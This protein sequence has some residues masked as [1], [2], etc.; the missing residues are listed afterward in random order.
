MKVFQSQHNYATP[1][2]RKEFSHRMLSILIA[3]F[4]VTTLFAV[5]LI[6]PEV[7]CAQAAGGDMP[8]ISGLCK[9]SKLLTGPI[10]G[11]IAI[12]ILAVMGLAYAA[13]EEKSVMGRGG[14]IIIGLS[15]TFFAASLV[16]YFMGAAV[17]GFLCR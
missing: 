17:S 3:G 8:W 7:A 15:F 1:A 6:T 13:G 9:V 16:E 10:A 11:A 5:S 12:I 14:Q 2:E 4:A